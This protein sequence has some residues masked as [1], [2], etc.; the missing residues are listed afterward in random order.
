MERRADF[1][2][3][4]TRIAPPQRIHRTTTVT[5]L[6]ATSVSHSIL[7]WHHTRATEEGS[8]NLLSGNSRPTKHGSSIE[9]SR[10]RG[11]GQVHQSDSAYLDDS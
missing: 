1:R 2:A 11:E 5:L 3:G 8:I 7:L 6:T 9:G 10:A 4:C